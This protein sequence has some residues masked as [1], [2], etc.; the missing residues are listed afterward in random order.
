MNDDAHIARGKIIK[1]R[2]RQETENKRGDFVHWSDVRGQFLDSDDQFKVD[3]FIKYISHLV[4]RRKDLK[5][6][7]EAVAK[8]MNI[9][10]ANLARIER[11]DAVP[12][13]DTFYKLITALDMELKLIPKDNFVDDFTGEK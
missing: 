4:M 10:Q 2:S 8:R 5:L 1:E 3:V 6:T 11:G 12:K 13:L 7:Q 9:T